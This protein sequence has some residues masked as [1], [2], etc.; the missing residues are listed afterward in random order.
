MQTAHVIVGCVYTSGCI[1]CDDVSCNEL[2]R[3]QFVVSLETDRGSG[4][5]SGWEE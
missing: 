5:T 2:C 3:N 4:D 1:Q